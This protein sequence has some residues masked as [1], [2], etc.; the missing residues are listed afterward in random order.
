MWEDAAF[1]RCNDFVVPSKVCNEEA[2][3]QQLLK[4]HCTF[5]LHCTL[6]AVQR[7]LVVS[8]NSSECSLSFSFTLPLSLSLPR[9]LHNL[10]LH[11]TLPEARHYL[12][13]FYALH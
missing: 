11:I 5:V 13:L 3:M 4:V 6:S 8:H 1:G 2:P 10:P 12:I 9:C 7:I